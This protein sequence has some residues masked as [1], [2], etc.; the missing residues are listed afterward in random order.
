MIQKSLFCF[1]FFNQQQLGVAA[2]KE[3]LWLN[4]GAENMILCVFLSMNLLKCQQKKNKGYEP[5][6]TKRA[7][8]SRV[9]EKN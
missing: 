3:L 9:V 8:E 7:W 6:R 1:I 4:M 5:V 2:T